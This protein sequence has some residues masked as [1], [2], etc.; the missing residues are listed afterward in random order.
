MRKVLVFKETLPAPSE[1]FILAQM[2]ALSMNP[3]S[4]ASSVRVRAF[5][6]ATSLSFCLIVGH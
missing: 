6:S 5:L 1:T 4:R 2:T 3:S